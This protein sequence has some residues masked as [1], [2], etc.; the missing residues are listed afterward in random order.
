MIRRKP[1][2][3]SWVDRV[4][5]RFSFSRTVRLGSSARTV[6]T[7]TRMASA[8]ARKRMVEQYDVRELQPR[9]SQLIREVAAQGRPSAGPESIAAWNQ[10]WGRDQPEWQRSAGLFQ[11]TTL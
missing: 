10:R 6:L 9:M 2:L 7:P 11:P 1:G 4:R 8:A 5:D 3:A